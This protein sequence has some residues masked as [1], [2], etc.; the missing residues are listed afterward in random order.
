[1]LQHWQNTAK[2]AI[3]AKYCNTGKILQNLQNA[4]IL[5]KFVFQAV[6]ASS[7]PSTLR[8]GVFTRSR[9]HRF[10]TDFH[11]RF[12][13]DFHGRLATGKLKFCT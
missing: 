4:E 5:A 9:H 6:E 12:V 13:T 8:V 3:L 1:M 10:P 11:G 2:L 7:V